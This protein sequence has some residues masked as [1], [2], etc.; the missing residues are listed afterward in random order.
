MKYSEKLNYAPFG[1]PHSHTSTL[2]LPPSP[3]SDNYV[4]TI[5]AG[6]DFEVNAPYLMYTHGNS[7]VWGSVRRG[8]GG[9]AGI[10]RLIHGISVNQAAMLIGR[11]HR[12]V[13]M[14]WGSIKPSASSDSM[15]PK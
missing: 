15:Y 13:C 2:P 5:H 12:R 7:E 1:Y 3:S 8:R 11:L 4:E 9:G 10:G 14:A 6:L